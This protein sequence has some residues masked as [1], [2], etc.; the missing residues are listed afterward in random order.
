MYFDA[1]KKATLAVEKPTQTEYRLFA[2]ITRALE[3]A[4]VDSATASDRIK[5]AFRNSQLW[6]T[7][8]LDLMSSENQLD[9]KTKA[10]L[11]SLA[12][13][14]EKYNREALTGKAS[15]APLISIN[16]NIMQG[17]SQANKAA[18]PEVTVSRPSATS[19][20]VAA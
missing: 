11:I 9:Q 20:V 13:W 18:L 12:I 6:Q 10:G 19:Q 4:S 3:L 16:K 1:Y 5:A 8:R 15:L 7:L 14:I 2:E 17:L